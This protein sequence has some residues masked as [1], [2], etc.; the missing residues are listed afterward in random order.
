M[1]ETHNLKNVVIFFQTILSF[2]FSRK[3]IN[4]YNDLAW[5][6]GNVTVKA[7][8]KYEKLEYKKN[9]LKLDID[10]LNHCKQLGLFPKFLII[11]LPNVSNKDASSIRKRLLRSTIN[12]CNKEL[13]HVLKELSISDNFLS[14]QLSTIEFYIINKSIISRN[15][16]SLQKS[17]Y[18]Q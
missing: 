13:Q 17:L 7:F 12:K 11:K 6:Y 3:I 5:K 2:V 9:K 8:R 4:I 14:K 1:I 15:N 18:T 10:F 16:K